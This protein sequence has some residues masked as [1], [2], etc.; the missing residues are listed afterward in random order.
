MGGLAISHGRNSRGKKNVFSLAEI[1]VLSGEELVGRYGIKTEQQLVDL[2]VTALKNGDDDIAKAIE[3][4]LNEVRLASGRPANRHLP[5]PPADDPD[6]GAW[7]QGAV[8][9]YARADQVDDAGA[10]RA[11]V[12]LALLYEAK[13]LERATTTH[14][15]RAGGSH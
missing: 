15:P 6:P 4:R 13:G 2:F 9:A 5:L 3:R 10:R 8:D 11:Y 14:R 7:T 1:A 12:D